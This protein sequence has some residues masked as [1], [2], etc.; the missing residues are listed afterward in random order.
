MQGESGRGVPTGSACL[1]IELIEYRDGPARFGARV[2]GKICT[3]PTT[4][5]LPNAVEG[6]VWVRSTDL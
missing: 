1:A 5:A 4:A 3:A 2:A 6:T